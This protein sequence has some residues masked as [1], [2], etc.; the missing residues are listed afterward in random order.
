M[1]GKL[2]KKLFRYWKKFT[3]K[4]ADSNQD[5]SQFTRR[6]VD[7]EQ[8]TV[9]ATHKS[10]RRDKGTVR[11]NLLM[12]SNKSGN[13][14]CF[15][16]IDLLP[17][18]IWEIAESHIKKNQVYGRGD[19]LAKT[20]YD[21]KL[22]FD[23]DNTP[24]RH[25][26]IVNW[27]DDNQAKKNKA[28]QIAA[29]STFHCQLTYNSIVSQVFHDKNNN[30]LSGVYILKGKEQTFTANTISELQSTFEDSVNNSKELSESQNHTT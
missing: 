14:S 4:P 8:I 20:I 18:Q 21:L 12:P 11:H 30:I 3:S 6:P 7:S 25:A 5:L 23:P 22:D 28:Q 9:Y 27:P 29:E 19:F 17:S 15:R 24:P 26:N 1:P 2:T 13:K 16:I 10:D